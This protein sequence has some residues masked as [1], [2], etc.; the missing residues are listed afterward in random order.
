MDLDGIPL[1]LLGAVDIDDDHEANVDVPRFAAVGYR[2]PGTHSVRL[3]RE[4]A[5]KRA[6]PIGGCN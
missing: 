2:Y 3:A 1:S 5:L 6:L 4:G